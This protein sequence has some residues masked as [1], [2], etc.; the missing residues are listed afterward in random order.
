[1]AARSSR[2]GLWPERHGELAWEV[3]LGVA[4]F[5]EGR[6][7]ESWARCPRVAVFRGV[8]A[9]IGRDPPNQDSVGERIVVVGR[10]IS[11]APVAFTIDLRVLR[12]LQLHKSHNAHQ[13]RGR[14]HAEQGRVGTGGRDGAAEPGMTGPWKQLKLRWDPFGKWGHGGRRAPGWQ[15]RVQRRIRAEGW[16]LWGHYVGRAVVPRQGLLLPRWGLAEDGRDL[17]WPVRV[18]C[19]RVWWRVR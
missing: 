5:S 15:A 12:Q 3:S 19:G 13:S 11:I 2:R 8:G 14:S 16:R 9:Q 7:R 10:G 18:L 6:S 1:M 4:A 17:R